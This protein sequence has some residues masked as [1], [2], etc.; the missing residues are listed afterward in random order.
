M[1]VQTKKLGVVCVDSGQLIICDPG[2]IDRYWKKSKQTSDSDYAHP[3]YRHKPT[4]TLWQ[5]T[6][7]KSPHKGVS[8]IPDNYGKVIP[9]FGKSAND[10]IKSKDFELTAMDP[11]PHIPQDEFSYRGIC[12]INDLHSQLQFPKRQSPMALAFT[13][14]LGDGQYEVHA[15]VVESKLLGQRI[16]KIWIEFISHEELA[17]LKKRER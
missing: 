14:G 9:E 10:L 11:T 8:Q 4:N 2:Y 1:N 12:K 7:G 5:F 15:E 16:T 3:I 13:S 6:Y 17:Y